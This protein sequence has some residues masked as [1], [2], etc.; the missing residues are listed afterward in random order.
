MTEAAAIAPTDSQVVNAGANQA[1]GSRTVAGTGAQSPTTGGAEGANGS[2]GGPPNPPGTNKYGAVVA[3]IV[4]I[5]VLLGFLIW[6]SIGAGGGAEKYPISWFIIIAAIL[7]SI[8][9]E[10]FR[11]GESHKPTYGWIAAYIFW[12]SAVSIVFAFLLYL[13]AIGELI[14][15]NMFPQFAQTPLGK[16]ASWT[17]EAFLTLVNPASHKDIAKIL[18]WS[19]IAGYSEKFVPNLIGQLLKSSEGKVKNGA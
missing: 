7:G 3:V 12:K 8:V 15:G 1:E 17:M 16:D 4:V 19:F 13:M 11:P 10:P 9:N 14:G 5:A 2:G 6:H 18:I